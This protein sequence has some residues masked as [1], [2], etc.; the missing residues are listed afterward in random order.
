MIP[1]EVNGLSRSVTILGSTGSIGV[2]TLDVVEALCTREGLDVQVAALAAGRNVERL[3]AQVLR[4]RPRYVAVADEQAAALLRERLGSAGAGLDIGVGTEGLIAAA[5]YPADTVVSAVSGA[6]GLLPTWHAVKRGARVAL[7][8]KESLVAG[9]KLVMS[10]A[11]TAGAQIIPV[12]SEHSALFQCLL[13]GQKGEVEAYVLTA[14]GGP[15]RTW[16]K[17]RMAAVTPKDALRHPNWT[18]GAKITVDSATL[19][20]KGLEVIEAHHLFDAPYDMI[21]VVIHPQSAVHSMVAYRDGSVVAQ[22]GPADMRIPIQYALTYPERTAAH[23]PRLDLVELGT[24]TFERPDEDRFPC[25][26]LAYEAGRAGG[27]APCVLNAANE[28]AVEAFLAGRLPFSGIPALVEDV[29]ASRADPEPA[30]LE[31]VFETDAAAR[32]SARSWLRKR[33]WGD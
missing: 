13:A 2:Q 12:D 11:R 26:R 30:R 22:L 28:V 5:Q 16:S 9:G 33:G 15:F 7:A 8:N 32:E 17:E 27:A 24:L 20:N 21:K 29:L 1:L 19:M 3:A 18:M 10:L 23:W 6:R 25:L 4:F 14:S 31:D